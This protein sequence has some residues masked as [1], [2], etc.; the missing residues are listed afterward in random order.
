MKACEGMVCA[1]H[2]WRHIVRGWKCLLAVVLACQV[3]L[4]QAAVPPWPEASFTFM[5]GSTRLIKVLNSFGQTFGLQVSLSDGVRANDAPIDGKLT[6]STPTEFLNQLAATYGLVWFYREG[7]LHVSR[8]NEITTRALPMPGGGTGLRTALSQLGLIDPKFGWGELAE[9][10]VVIVTGPPTY[11]DLIEK[12]IAA[13]PGPQ[14]SEQVKVF[15]LQHASVDDRTIQYRDKQLVTA[16]VATIL[17]NLVSGQSGKGSTTVPVVELASPL[18]A[19]GPVTGDAATPG[20]EGAA[21][22]GPG[23]APHAAGA[24]GAAAGSGA[25]IGPGRPII[26]ADSRLNAVIVR[27]RP[28][29]MP[30]YEQLIAI[31]DTPSQLI[32]IEAAIVDVNTTKLAELGIDWNAR[33][34]RFAG[35]FGQ[36]EVARTGTTLN[37]VR[38]NGVNP[39]TVI[40]D[41]GNFLMTR[42]NALESKGDARVV[43]RPSVLTVDNLGALIDLS[44]TFY[45]Q[46][47]GE[48]AVSVVPISVGV[49][50][51]VTPHI[52]G[53]EGSRAVHLVVDIED[54]AIQETKVQNLPTVRRSTIGTQAV[55]AEQESLLIGGFNS[56]VKA[57]SKDGVPVLGDMPGLGALFSKEK[58]DVQKR[59]RMFLI[60][61]R[62][63]PSA[64]LG[65]P[66]AVGPTA[67]AR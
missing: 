4:V 35:G 17:R 28:D 27:A 54:G 10:G 44:E 53:N 2:G 16:G 55:V 56:E 24:A 50:L 38:G 67:A 6:A 60:T 65:P 62:V 18:R 51:R 9:R 40:A 3:A 36:P 26:Q 47:I 66:V 46:T 31:L 20:A 12:T 8:V 33:A 43:S 64:A 52:I 21:P 49:T 1:M 25:A 22:A 15:R 57:R 37:L 61:P 34:G 14:A 58:T 32:E 19:F 48:R 42:I 41:A 30:I 63:V 5:G 45:I 59:E 39:A 23:G 29:D 7:T 13:L 11:V